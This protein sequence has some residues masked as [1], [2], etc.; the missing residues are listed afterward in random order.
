V[1][2]TL[3]A[4]A[5][6]AAAGPSTRRLARLVPLEGGY[7]TVLAAAAVLAPWGAA[8]VPL[9]PG[10]VALGLAGGAGVALVVRALVRRARASADAHAGLVAALA[11]AAGMG[12]VTGVSPFVL[13]ALVAAVA[14][15][16][17][18]H[19]HALRRLRRLLARG[20]RLAV[21]GLGLAAAPLLARPT[22]WLLAAGVL[23][24]GLGAAGGWAAVRWGGMLLRVPPWPP[25]AP[26]A[27]TLAAPGSLGLA[28]A[29]NFGLM[30][31]AGAA[32]LT[33][34][35]IAVL[36][37]RLAAPALGRLVTASRAPLRP[38]AGGAEFRADPPADW[39]AP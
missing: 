32:V 27:P 15:N 9:R 37:A 14:V 2:L 17:A 13:C 12:Y 34:A 1:L 7:V 21:A 18:R 8:R 28:L 30:N 6:A 24:A 38:A 23:L 31:D 29:V 26:A 20:E 4:V 33:V 36:A 16:A 5:A 19:R 39:T 25:A 35:V 3:A 10:A 11:L 22:A